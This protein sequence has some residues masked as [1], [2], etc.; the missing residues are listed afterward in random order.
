MNIISLLFCSNYNDIPVNAEKSSIALTTFAKLHEKKDHSRVLLVIRKDWMDGKCYLEAAKES[1]L[2]LWD[3]L[4]Q[5]FGSHA[6]LLSNVKRVVE[7]TMEDMQ[8][9][10]QPQKILLP[11]EQTRA[12]LNK[13]L[14]KKYHDI[15]KRH[16][17]QE[18]PFNRTEEELKSLQTIARGGISNIGA[19]CYLA[20]VFQSLFSS[21]AF[22][23]LVHEKRETVPIAAL[24]DRAF[25]EMKK[26]TPLPYETTRAIMQSCL[27]QGWLKEKDPSSH[28]TQQDPDSLLYFLMTALR[29][30]DEI[31]QFFTM[32]KE[33]LKPLNGWQINFR[34]TPGLSLQEWLDKPHSKRVSSI[35]PPF[36]AITID[37]R[38]QQTGKKARTPI[39]IPSTLTI[40]Q[41]ET[42]ERRETYELSSVI[43][44]EGENLQGGHYYTYEPL[45]NNMGNIAAW[46]AY[47]DSYVKIYSK[48]K[49]VLEIIEA[50][51]Q[52]GYIFF[53]THEVSP[54]LP[55]RT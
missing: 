38:C 40:P 31:R 18:V 22:M 41:K 17:I 5:F 46:K 53:Y 55:S 43:M 50:L 21:P 3:R 25:D 13:K 27:E 15:H 32:R 12:I 24:L 45:Y 48:P 36:L 4:R 30:T 20:S 28:Y 23:S 37:G 52:E 51:S 19:S 44:F 39:A 7:K 33:S 54:I 16:V 2:N 26:G 10:P 11:L 34:I 47:N 9:S 14:F 8:K 49:K 29:D 42:P 35:A 6:F 1:D